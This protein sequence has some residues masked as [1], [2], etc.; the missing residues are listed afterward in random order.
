VSCIGSILSP[1]CASLLGLHIRLSRESRVPGGDSSFFSDC[2]FFL[3][4]KS[5][6]FLLTLPV[7]F[8]LSTGLLVRIFCFS[9]CLGCFGLGKHTTGTDESILSGTL[10]GSL[11]IGDPLGLLPCFNGVCGC[12][13]SD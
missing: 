8:C 1:L 2:G 6:P 7:G 13:L 10:F 3:G 4:Q 11:G 9:C 12:D 5:D